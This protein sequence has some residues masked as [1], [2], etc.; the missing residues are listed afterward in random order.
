MPPRPKV[1]ASGG[2]P[3]TMS[4]G[5]AR[6][7]CRGQVSQAA[8]TSRW[9]WTAALGL[10]VVPEVKASRAM[11]SPAVGQAGKLPLLRAAIASSEV[12]ALGS[13]TLKATMRRSTG[14]LAW[15]CASSSCSF[16]SHNAATGRAFS[17]MSPSSLARSSGMVATA[18]MPARTTASHTSAM[19]IELPPRSNTRLPGS[20]PRSCTSTWWM[21]DT[22]AAA[23][24]YVST[25]SGERNIGRP[26]VPLSAARSSSSWTR[27][28][29]PGICSSGNRS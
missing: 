29:C 27:L 2:E 24:A 8:S 5:R 21:A 25:T 6:S 1:K 3:I 15:A 26:A 11:S 13:V 14:W 9:E 7:T 4:S 20:S 28:S 10:P 19:P 23:C 18:T 17:M 16:A 22:R 12:V